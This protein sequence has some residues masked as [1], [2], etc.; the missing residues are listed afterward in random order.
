M[1][2]KPQSKSGLTEEQRTQLLIAMQEAKA[3]GLEVDLDI[4][5][6]PIIKWP[7]DSNG[8]FTKNDGK[9]FQPTDSHA[10]FVLSTAVFAAFIGARGSGKSASGAQKALRKVEKGE[11]GAV[12]NP[13]FENFKYSTWPELKEWIPWGTVVPSQR[14][15]ANPDWSPHQPFTMVFLNGA[16]MYCKGLKNPDSARGP[17]INWLWYDEGGRDDTGLG[18]KIA[19]AGV[20]IGEDP[21]AWVTAT[22]SG[23]DHWIYEFFY[24]KEIPEDALEAFEE[25]AKDRELVEFFHGSIFDN[26]DNLDPTFFAS[27]LATYPSGWLRQ[28]EIFGEFVD[29]GG[30]LG[31]TL[32]FDGKKRTEPPFVVHK[33]VRFWDLA[34]SEKKVAKKGRRKDEP[35]ETCG[36]LVCWDGKEQF[37]IEDQVAGHWKW[38][39]LKQSIKDTAKLDGIAVPIYIEQEPGSGGKNQIAAIQEEFSEDIELA[40][41][42]VIGFFPRDYGDKIMRANYWF[43]E[44]ANGQWYIIYAPWNKKF[45][46]QLGSFPGRYD[47]Y[48]DSISGARLCIAPIKKWKKIKFLHMGSKVEEDDEEEIT[49]APGV[50]KL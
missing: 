24:E 48:I 1:K 45:F 4:V 35:D 49:K 9:F 41:H 26:K 2:R 25:V 18:W 29:E 32:W 19:V 6:P 50:M 17:N 20:R 44:A 46:K 8:Y 36:S 27:M 42:K 23:R 12:F 13:D 38:K 21:Q 34:A 28:Q 14:F 39:Q 37:C 40:G 33:R 22:P 43:A 47:D 11:P 16:K 3:R 30:V 31:S 10:G 7:I 15:R 5:K